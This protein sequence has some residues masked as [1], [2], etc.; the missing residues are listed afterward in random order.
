MNI[1][2]HA[3]FHP[4]IPLFANFASLLCNQHVLELGW[5]AT[6]PFCLEDRHVTQQKRYSAANALIKA[7]AKK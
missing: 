3:S 2:I 4:I 1:T 6:L 7:N 5:D